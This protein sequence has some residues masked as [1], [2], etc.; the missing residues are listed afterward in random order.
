MKKSKISVVLFMC[1][2]LFVLNGCGL[3]GSREPDTQTIPDPQR[4]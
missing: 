1:V 4:G 2:L 3:F